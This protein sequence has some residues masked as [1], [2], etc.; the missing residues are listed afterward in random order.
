M[1]A[2]QITKPTRE[3]ALHY[4]GMRRVGGEAQMRS[5]AMQSQ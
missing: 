3:K 1:I 2:Q 5:L 4:A